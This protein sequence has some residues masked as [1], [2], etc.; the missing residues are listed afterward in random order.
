MQKIFIH[1]GL[2]ALLRLS[3]ILNNKYGAL[4]AYAN[5]VP[6]L[7]KTIERSIWI[8]KI[9]VLWKLFDTD[10]SNLIHLYLGWLVFVLL[11]RKPRRFRLGR[12]CVHIFY[13]CFLINIWCLLT[14]ALF[15]SSL[16]NPKGMVSKNCRKSWKWRK[17]RIILQPLGRNFEI[18]LSKFTFY[19]FNSLLN[20]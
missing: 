13:S 11:T 9:V 15:V 12:N 2:S 8:Q 16:Q 6:N 1:I 10:A 20:E 18:L 19:L 3:H 4:L 14:V 7:Y 17:Q 5:L